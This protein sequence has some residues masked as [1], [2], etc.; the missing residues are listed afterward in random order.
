M[1]ILGALIILIATTLIGF[2]FANRLS[3]RPKQLRHLKYAL[4][5]LEAEIMFGHVP[6][7]EASNRLA[8]QVPKPIATI[9]LLFSSSLEEE[10]TNVKIA[11]EKTLIKAWPETALGKP[12]FEILMQFGATLGQHDR[13]QQ[14]KQIRLTLSHLE[15]EEADARDAQARHEKMLKS[16]GVLSGLLIIVLLM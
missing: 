4:Q 14:Q 3:N 6:L 10:S 12:E 13:V 15:R 7:K 9:F 2:S 11:W 1:K 16:L 8:A 5:T